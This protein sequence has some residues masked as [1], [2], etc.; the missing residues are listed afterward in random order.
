MWRSKV[1]AA[2]LTAG[3]ALAGL[4]LCLAAPTLGVVTILQIATTAGDPTLRA[5]G[6]LFAVVPTLFCVS[7]LAIDVMARARASVLGGNA[8]EAD[9]VVRSAIAWALVC[10]TLTVLAC[11]AWFAPTVWP[12][13]F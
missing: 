9:G 13:V 4:V 12:G 3:I 2:A 10:G 6:T 11:I 5:L 8:A 7:C 1:I